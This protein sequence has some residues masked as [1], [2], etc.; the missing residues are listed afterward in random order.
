MKEENVIKAIYWLTERIAELQCYTQPASKGDP[1]TPQ[2]I[3]DDNIAD[4]LE[5]IKKVLEIQEEKE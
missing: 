2:E 5:R 1:R 3:V 4:K